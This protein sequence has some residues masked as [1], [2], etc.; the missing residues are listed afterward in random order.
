MNHDF[1]IPEIQDERNILLQ[2]VGFL[3]SA[4]LPAEQIV[5]K[6]QLLFIYDKVSSFETHVLA[7]KSVSIDFTD[8]IHI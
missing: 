4:S 6:K 3:F 2:N 7:L 1:T 5:E 8:P